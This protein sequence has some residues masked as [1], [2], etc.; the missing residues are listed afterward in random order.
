[1]VMV[2]SMEYAVMKDSCNGEILIE[3]IYPLVWAGKEMN[4]HYG[5]MNIILGFYYQWEQYC[6]ERSTPSLTSQGV[7]P[8]DIYF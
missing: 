1:M 8:N 4:G 2:I 3:R 5:V 6:D 7:N